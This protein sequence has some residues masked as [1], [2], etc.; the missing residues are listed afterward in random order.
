VPAQPDTVSGCPIPKKAAV[1]QGNGASLPDHIFRSEIPK[2]RFPVISELPLGW[3]RRLKTPHVVVLEGMR[4]GLM[5]CEQ[6]RPL[7]PFKSFL[8]HVGS[9]KAMI[10]FSIN[11]FLLKAY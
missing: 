7:N 6:Q 9:W 1:R 5:Q 3:L 10:S 8:Q 2:G 4:K 11:C